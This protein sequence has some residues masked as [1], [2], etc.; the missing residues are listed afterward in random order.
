MAHNPI[1]FPIDIIEQIVGPTFSSAARQHWASLIDQ[2]EILGID[3]S[4]LLHWFRRTETDAVIPPEMRAAMR[5]VGVRILAKQ[6]MITPLVAID[7]FHKHKA[8]GEYVT[9]PVWAFRRNEGSHGKLPPKEP[10]KESHPDGPFGIGGVRWKGIEYAGLAPKPFK[11]VEMLWNS[12]NRTCEITSAMEAI[13]GEKYGPED[14]LAGLR[15]EANRFFRKHKIGLE[16]KVSGDLDRV[17][18]NHRGA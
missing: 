10:Q 14:G 12:R 15:R 7:E 11:L 13:Y 17:A 4:E 6:G 5:R 1:E 8:A 16:V 18:L 2:A 9:F 3:A